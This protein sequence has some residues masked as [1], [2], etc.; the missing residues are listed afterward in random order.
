MTPDQVQQMITT[1]LTSYD[2]NQRFGVSTVPFHNHNGINSP[3]IK[4]PV[5][6][7]VGYIGPDGETGAIFPKGWSV[8]YTNVGGVQPNYTIFHNLGNTNYT[9]VFTSYDKA[10]IPILYGLDETGSPDYGKTANQISVQW[11]DPVGA[12]LAQNSFQFALIL[13]TTSQNAI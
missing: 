5:T 10:Y 8:Q 7:Y 4:T 12:A 1:A 9:I 3:V 13:G 11:Y 6:S 2:Q